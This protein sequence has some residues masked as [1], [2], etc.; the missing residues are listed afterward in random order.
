MLRVNLFQNKL[1]TWDMMHHWQ[2]NWPLIYATCRNNPPLLDKLQ[3]MIYLF[4]YQSVNNV[5]SVEQKRSFKRSIQFIS[6]LYIWIVIIKLLLCACNHFSSFVL[7]MQC[8]I[9]LALVRQ[10]IRPFK[11][12]LSV[13][14]IIIIFFFKMWLLFI[15]AAFVLYKI[16]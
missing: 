5:T 7:E 11:G 15:K 4:L 13:R 8:V 9:S 2:L 6:V 14:I 16:Q 10:N 12:L 3:E 1:M